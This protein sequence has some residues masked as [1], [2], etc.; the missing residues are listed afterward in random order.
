M[1]MLKIKKYYFDAFQNK[2]HFKNNHYF[3]ILMHFW[4]K[5]CNVLFL[6]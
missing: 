2:K 1:M 6:Y 4:C 3:N 5:P